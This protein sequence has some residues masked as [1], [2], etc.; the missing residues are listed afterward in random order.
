[1][2]ELI[3][4]LA[5]ISFG[6]LIIKYVPMKL[7]SKGKNILFAIGAIISSLGILAT[8]SYTLWTGLLSVLIIGLLIS[9]MSQNRLEG[10]FEHDSDNSSMNVNHDSAIAMDFSG[11]TMDNMTTVPDEDYEQEHESDPDESEGDYLFSEDDELE[12]SQKEVDSGYSTDVDDHPLKKEEETPYSESEEE[13]VESRFNEASGLNLIEGEEGNDDLNPIE[14]TEETL[15]DLEREIDEE[16]EADDTLHPSSNLEED[17]ENWFM[18]ENASPSY[19]E[20]DLMDN[21]QEIDG[22]TEEEL[23]SN[24]NIEDLEDMD[25]ELEENEL[26]LVNEE[27]QEL[28]NESTV[29]DVHDRDPSILEDED[30]DDWGSEIEEK[31]YEEETNED[32]VNVSEPL[33]VEEETPLVED[34]E[35]ISYGFSNEDHSTLDNHSLQEEWDDLNDN[36]EE[37]SENGFAASEVNEVDDNY[38][39]EAHE[40]HET[41]ADEALR[42]QL[43]DLM[44][45]KIIFMKNEMSTRD[46]EV[47]IK[48]HLTE[49]LPDLEYYTISK[50]LM[51]HYIQEGQ[52]DVLDIFTRQLMDKMDGYPLL[53]EELKG[54]TSHFLQQSRQ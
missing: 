44:V 12:E 49:N 18:E 26:S 23:F 21:L 50:Y 46:Y 54:Y 32:E 51:N 2:I 31:N 25:E 14:D 3:S 33:A 11:Y 53:V 47:Y 38:L 35:S 37:S 40:K 15:F 22:L 28:H 48:E 5:A 13:L 29:E 1:M 36:S 30:G 42:K 34:E 19:Q 41:I 16:L 45:E 6:Y 10:I 9:Y 20:G 8:I 27:L 39:S 7:T 17:T 52:F 4:W 24:R 43:L